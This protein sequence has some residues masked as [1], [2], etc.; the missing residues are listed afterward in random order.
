MSADHHDHDLDAEPPK[1][2]GLP[3]VVKYV[4][5]AAFLLS[6]GLAIPSFYAKSRAIGPKAVLHISRG[7][8]AGPGTALLGRPSHFVSAT[9]TL[10]SEAWPKTSRRST[11]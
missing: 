7:V 3:P 5:G 11:G 1:R 6:A 4:C 9:I 2:T 10:D 8:A